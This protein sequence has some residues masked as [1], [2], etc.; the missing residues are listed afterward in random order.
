M[1]FW[2]MKKI[3]SEITSGSQKG[4]FGHRNVS[5]MIIYYLLSI[6]MVHFLYRK[7]GIFCNCIVCLINKQW[8]LSPIHPWKI[9]TC[10]KYVIMYMYF[11][12]HLCR[13]AHF[14]FI[15]LWVKLGEDF[16]IWS[17]FWAFRP[18]CI[19]NAGYWSFLNL[20]KAAHEKQIPNLQKSF[21]NQMQSKE[22]CQ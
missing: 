11:S 14:H 7:S 20:L 12:V 13:E 18:N 21:N 16:Q 4:K 6:T 19:K 10:T 3:N 17:Y 15:E 5:A 8:L 2:Y 9:K 1:F 22:G